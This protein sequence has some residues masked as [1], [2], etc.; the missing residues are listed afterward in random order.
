MNNNALFESDHAIVKL[1]TRINSVLHLDCKHSGP[2]KNDFRYILTSIS[3]ILNSVEIEDAFYFNLEE[4][5][6]CCIYDCQTV[7]R[8]CPLYAL[9]I[10]LVHK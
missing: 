2:N 5:F 3:V 4:L 6:L 8:V 7:H 9:I 1:R 10:L